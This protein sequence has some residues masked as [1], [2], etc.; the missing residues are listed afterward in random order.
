M[1]PTWSAAALSAQAERVA[2]LAHA[3]RPGEAAL[4]VARFRYPSLD[5]GHYLN[6]MEWM[7]SRV[8]GNT[9]LALRRVIAIAEGI[10]GNVEDYHAPENGFLN[11]V[12]DTRRG[13][14]TC[15]SILWK[16]VGRIAGI[17]VVGVGLPG[18]FVVYAAGQMVDPFHFGEAIGF[19]EAAAL[20]A[21]AMGGPARL[22]RSWLSPVDTVGMIHRLLLDL[23]ESFRGRGD[24]RSVEWVETALGSL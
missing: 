2:S 21:A 23:E 7:A 20:V 5:V 18:H 13:N 14:P 17:E 24:D 16:E 11:R 12:I 19:D 4:E 22:D 3:D 10:G 6:R 8:N 15:L 9:H 1:T